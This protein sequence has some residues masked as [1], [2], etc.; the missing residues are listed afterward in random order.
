MQTEKNIWLRM[1]S[2]ILTLALLISCV[3]NQVYAMA[4]EALAELMEQEETAETIEA[5]NKTKRDV[6]EVTELREANVKHFALEDGTYTAVMYG[7][8]VHT[9]DAEGNWQDIDNRLSDSGSEFST[10]N[11]R[12]KFAKKITGNETLF[13]L[14]DGNRKITMSLDDAIKKTTGTV[15][16]HTTEFDSDATQLQ[17]LM[18]LDNLSSEILYADI[19]DG[20]DLQYVVESLNVKENIIVKERKDRYQYTFTIALNNLEAEMADD[21]SV[22]IYD[23]TNKETV[24]NI[25]AGFMY[26]AN[27]EYS[28]AV[29]YTLTNSGNGKYSLAVTTDA[30]W[31]NAE[32]RVFPV[33]IDPTISPGSSTSGYNATYIKASDPDTIL[34]DLSSLEVSGDATAYWKMHTLPTLPAGYHITDARFIANGPGAT[35][36]AYNIELGVHQVISDWDVATLCYS[37]HES[38]GTGRF[39]ENAIDAK[40]A[41]N[42]E[43]KCVWNITQI[44]REWYNDPSCN[45]G[46]AIRRTNTSTSSDIIELSFG[47]KALPIRITYKPIR[48]LEDHWS[49]ASQNVGRAG[50]GYVNKA[51]GELTFTIGTLA[52]TDA[53]FGHTTTLIYNQVIAG[54][55]FTRDTASVPLV[56][57]TCGY[58]MK[59]N[60]NESIIS[61]TYV[62]KWG[63]VTSYYIWTDADGT[64]H[65]F[66]HSEEVP[67]LY[68]DNDGLLLTLTINGNIYEITDM[69]HNV[70]TFT[71]N[72]TD[73]TKVKNGFILHSIT[74]KNGNKLVYDYQ[75]DGKVKRIQVVPNGS[76]VISYF[77]FTYNSYGQI[78]SIEYDS[79]DQPKNTPAVKF[80][81][82]PNYYVTSNISPNYQGYL[83]KIE[84]IN[85]QQVVA[86]TS[87]EYNSNGKLIAA[88]DDTAGYSV[89]YS[90]SGNRVSSITEYAGVSNM[91]GQTIALSYG[92]GY[93]EIRTSGSDD[94]YGTNDDIITV[95]IFDEYA[96]VTSTYSTDATKTIIYGASSG[97]Y[98]DQENVK[99]NIKSSVS[100]GGAASNYIFN[101]GF[102]DYFTSL[103]TG[104]QEAFG[105]DS[106]INVSFE[107]YVDNAPDVTSKVGEHSYA[108][109]ALHSDAAY[110][111]YQDVEIPAGQYTLSVDI[112][113]FNTLNVDAVIQV[114]SQWDD[115]RTF[116]K[117]IPL[118][119]YD[120]NQGAVTFSMNFEAIDCGGAGTEEFR[121]MIGA[122]CGEIYDL[123]NTYITVDNVML[124]EGI[125]NSGFSVVEFGNFEGF[126]SES[127]YKIHWGSTATT[128]WENDLLGDVLVVEA[129]QTFSQ[130]LYSANSATATLGPRSYT[131]S[132]MA[133]GSGQYASEPFEIKVVVEYFNAPEDTQTHDLKFQCISNE[134]QFVCKNFTTKAGLMVE[135]ITLYLEYGMHPGEARFD[136]IYMTQVIG[137]ETTNTEYYENGLLHVQKTG[138]YTEVYEYDN[139]NN[140]ARVANNQ[141]QIYD[142]TYTATNNVD[143]VTYY[144]FKS[145]SDQGSLLDYPYWE[146][147]IESCIVKTPVSRTKYTYN[148]YCL[149]AKEDTYEVAY[150]STKTQ[151]VEKTDSHHVVSEY[152]YYTSANS[153]VFG[154]TLYAIDNEGVQTRYFLD[155]TLGHLL[156][157]INTNNYTGTCYTYDLLGNIETVTPAKYTGSFV[158]DNNAEKVIY[159]YNAEK[160]L[161]T[162]TTRSTQYRFEYD[163]FGNTDSIAVGNN[164]IASYDYNQH[165]GKMTAIHYANG[166]SIRYVYNELENVSEVWY[167]DNDP[168]TED[169][170][171]YAYSYT[172]YGQV[173]RFDNL[174]T[175]QSIIYEYDANH[176]LAG[177]VEFDTDEMTNALS[178]AIKYNNKSQIEVL[179][180]YF[181][182]SY[183]LLRVSGNGVSYEY[184]YNDD[185]SVKST[186][187]EGI[188]TDGTIDYTYDAFRRLSKK[189]Y[190]YT[191][192]FDGNLQGVWGTF[193]N[194]VEYTYKVNESNGKTS[195]LVE[196]FTSKI[197]NSAAQS[198][199]YEYDY[200][201]NITRIVLPSGEEY[202]YKYDDLGQ[203][204]REDNTVRGYTYVYEYNS[205]GN[206]TKK[207]IY[208][209]TAK[210]DTPT[211]PQYTYD[212]SYGDTNWG[213][214]L[215]MYRGGSITY[216]EV[217]NPLSYYNGRRYTFAWENGRRLASAETGA[218]E[219]EFTYNDEGIR[220]S[221]TINGIKH[222][223]HLNGSQ[224][225]TEAWENHL[226]VYLYDAEGNPIGMQYRNT[227]MGE[228]EF[229]EYWYEKNLQG[230]IVAVYDAA[231]TK[232]I[233][234]TYDAW[235]N[236]IKQYH[237]GCTSSN[238]VVNNPFLYRGYYFD[239]ELGMYYLQSR[240]YDPVI[241]RFINADGMVST[242]QGLLGYNMY[243]YCGN[244][245]VCRA[246]YSGQFWGVVILAAVLVVALSGCSA[247]DSDKNVLVMSNS[248]E[249]W[250][251]S[252]Q[253]MGEDMASAVGT[254]SSS[255]QAVDSDNFA[256]T[257]NKTTAD[258]II[259][260]THGSPDGLFGTELSFRTRDVSQLHS[261]DNINFVLIT[262][263][264]TGGMNSSGANIAS[265]LSQKISPNGIVVCCT[266]VVSG[267]DT[268]FTATNN[269]QWIAY[270]NGEQIPCDLPSTITMWDVAAYWGN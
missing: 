92:D 270:R 122:K 175:N 218:L 151:I 118:D 62:D 109:F 7:G 138:H 243:A 65:E 86:T 166:H 57:P 112:Q 28:T 6:Y 60:V 140:L 20:V 66:Y 108:H 89:R 143:T 74:D 36:N 264:E 10:S 120:A 39:T 70:R 160:L 117:E 93:T 128:E 11:A 174:L 83:K 214:K 163:P 259:I 15:T 203:L 12:I 41:S 263:C 219:F 87:Y 171:L 133:R 67:N 241:G 206:I 43:S 153:R 56:D 224:I 78:A 193:T 156:M 116:R 220:T 64:E 110:F 105:W 23:P 46:I 95:Y 1:L 129:G 257:W 216:D 25:P 84:F 217:G 97:E 168:G 190:R 200:N 223:Y 251:T 258:H 204:L 248:D 250:M 29:V 185:G 197:N 180:Y 169:I 135:R 100:V 269:G 199:T 53:L 73:R 237:N 227:A 165:N 59:L 195:P 27:G 191:S 3:P 32:E 102:E 172:A 134:W 94:Q 256:D 177:F 114:V 141:G 222:T 189:V 71:K 81:Y 235:G 4:G 14:H 183:Q 58:G 210:N 230:D 260:H 192:A 164:Q 31:I 47:V 40:T 209:P 48:G 198:Y 8:A 194:T 246:D 107:K 26:D 37:Q 101:G 147:N 69:N 130:T 261:N 240:Y 77:I 85:Q 132:G 17:K 255:V 179:A 136:N 149:V 167:A 61:K 52:T 247:D 9:Q 181:D 33:V 239:N 176:R 42:Q 207:Y 238:P 249:G 2:M 211:N 154:A 182:Y 234:Y 75:E 13:T 145:T 51:T 137:D 187:V 202:R 96:R 157:V 161:D 244:N 24:Y 215:T 5:P 232:L 226:L 72:N 188:A 242:G 103:T 34:G 184:A 196:K 91:Q 150:N 229:A 104:R 63:D 121:V 146:G 245:P 254:K 139:R 267:G 225:I 111:I 54:Q 21:G 228:D 35:G 262:A 30:A 162:I 155:E 88:H 68:L 127:T 213:D 99:N 79:D 142:Y 266:T 233:S 16:N 82:S 90:Y 76:A 208:A 124:E 80:Y 221:K 252:S 44:V 50:T 22:R 159:T 125:G 115:T 265:L 38:I 123:T 131:V 126:S 55:Y 18:T 98:E 170:Q 231:G 144:T 253:K 186:G 201:G 148:Q 158:P 212:Y 49:F 268:H 113:C 119:D 173:Y 106:N 236:F 19:L 152:A 45:Y 205:A 178:A